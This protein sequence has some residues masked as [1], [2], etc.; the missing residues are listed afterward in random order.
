M[1]TDKTVI[2]EQ[3]LPISLILLLGT[4]VQAAVGFGAGLVS[5]PLLVWRDIPLPYAVGLNVA[6]VCAQTGFN[7]WQHRTELPWRHVLPMFLLRGATLPFGVWLMY[8]VTE[9]DPSSTKQV[10]GVVL[11]AILLAQSRWRIS[12]RTYVP[13]RWTVLAGTLSGVMAGMVGMGA[14]PVVFWLMAHDWSATRQRTF[15]WL[16]FLALIPFHASLL[17]WTFGRPMITAFVV[18]FALAPAGLAGAWLG[19]QI[20]RRLSRAKLRY[21]MVAMLFGI[22]LTS[23]AAPWLDAPRS[24]AEKARAIPIHTAGTPAT[25]LRHPAVAAAGCRH[26][27]M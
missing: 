13:W 21:A 27:G 16:T 26:H 24:A 6:I 20:G 2:I 22:A 10:I 23:I 8:E 4:A 11:L 9:L 1:P 5:V 25:W 19:G 18:G 7:C 14:A 12:P 15:L 3:I 17:G